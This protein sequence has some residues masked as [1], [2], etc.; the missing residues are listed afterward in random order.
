MGHV[1]D[2]LLLHGKEQTRD[3]LGNE[4]VLADIASAVMADETRQMGFTYS[5][6]CLTGLP[7]R[8][9][10]NETWRRDGHRIT[11]II[12]SG[13]NRLGNPCG[14]P[15]GSTARMILLYLQTRALQSNSRYVEIG[16]S[17]NSWLDH[18]GLPIGGKT[19][20]QVR[21]QSSR[22]SA[23]HLT[24]FYDRQGGG[25][26]RHNGAFVENALQLSKSL[27]EQEEIWQD[28][29][30]LNEKFFRALKEHPVP[31]LDVAIRQIS[32]KSLALDIYIWL[33]YRLHRLDKPTSIFWPA[34]YGQF[35]A[36]IKALK[37]FKPEFTKNLKLALAAYPEA[38]VDVQEDG[39]VLWQSHAPVSDRRIHA[40]R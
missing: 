8:D 33:A 7:H 39:I 32:G 24:F 20:R 27:P 6:F 38:R 17:M 37:H 21:E 31:L 30:E 36:G 19:Y 11:L 26:V 23:C 13:K 34:L 15:Y 10:R 35:G 14:I 9:P 3:L 5:G 4:R 22:I 40:V 1:H 28:T 18:M 12:E 2:L 25:E 29:V 16:R